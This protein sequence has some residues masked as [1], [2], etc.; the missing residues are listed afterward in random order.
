M[1]LTDAIERGTW[2][3]H[4][5]QQGTGS[6]GYTAG[7]GFDAYVRILH[8]VPDRDE[9]IDPTLDGAWSTRRW[10]DVAARNGRTMHRLVQWGRL[11]GLDEPEQVGHQP[12]P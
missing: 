6:V 9:V 1:H 8:P 5:M 4:R 3:A 11:L 10:A 7:A 2:L 12:V